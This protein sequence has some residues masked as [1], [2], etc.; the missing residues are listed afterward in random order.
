MCIEIIS[1]RGK[2]ITSINKIAWHLD[3][4]LGNA[5]FWI[6]HQE[7]RQ[8]KEKQTGGTVSNYKSFCTTG[9]SFTK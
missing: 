5:Y 4:C 9:E 8:Q 2:T 3:I 1:K 6:G 7:Q